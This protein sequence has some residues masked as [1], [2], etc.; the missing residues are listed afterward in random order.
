MKRGTRFSHRQHRNHGLGS[1]SLASDRE[2]RGRTGDD[3]GLFDTPY[4][5]YTD[6]GLDGEYCRLAHTGQ[7][8]Q[9]D[10]HKKVIVN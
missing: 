10:S 7:I 9:K 8:L 5:S 3:A 1:V 2:M 4:T 6:E